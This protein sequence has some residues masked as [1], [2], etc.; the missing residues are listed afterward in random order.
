SEAGRGFPV[1]PDVL[2]RLRIEAAN[3]VAEVENGYI[4]QPQGHADRCIAIPDGLLHHGLINAHDH[5]HRNHYGRLGDGAYPNAYVWAADIQHHHSQ[6]IAA[7]RLLP[8]RTALLWGAW[9]NL[10]AGVTSVVHHDAWEPD[11][12]RDFPLRV[13][14]I[15]CGDS[16]GMTPDL[17]P[18]PDGLFALHVAE[19]ID[20]AAAEEVHQLAACGLM[21]ER[22]LAVHVVGPDADGVDMLHASGCA[23]AWCPTSNHFLFGRTTP[24]ALLADGR[25]DILLGTDSLLTGA[26]N[27]L[28]ELRAARE[29]ALLPDS[30]L[31]ASVGAS[32]ARRLGL[33]APSL[34][35]GARADLIVLRRPLLESGAEDIA[36]VM[37]A[38]A[39]RVLDTTLLPAAGVSG[40]QQLRRGP[41]VR[42]ISEDAVLPQSDP[43][44]CRPG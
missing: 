42:W 15:A 39:L 6:T 3:G 32:A 28:D 26:G 25:I 44:T 19:G 17:A 22:L 37:A 10:L 12:E 33:P 14:R 41:V 18:P 40:G 30:R 9:K 11:F 21:N 7:G 20:A 34:D 16:L 24:R 38:G 29:T 4:V 35:P 13:I 43:A 31:Q 5:L 8:R 1:P 36:L 27:L 23:I 2:M